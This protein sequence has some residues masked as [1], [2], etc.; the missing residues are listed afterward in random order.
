M[1]AT[2][3]RRFAEHMARARSR[4]E[5]AAS[6]LCETHERED[7]LLEMARGI[8]GITAQ[9]DKLRERALGPSVASSSRRTR[10]QFDAWL[11]S[12]LEPEA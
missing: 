4:L 6:I 2:E 5:L 3:E 7:A 11:K 9:I 12:K 1:T 8:E 10:E